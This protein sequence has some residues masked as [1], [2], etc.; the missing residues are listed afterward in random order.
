[1]KQTISIVHYE[2]K[3]RWGCAIKEASLLRKLGLLLVGIGDKSKILNS[4]Q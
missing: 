4:S 3:L 1:M 2:E